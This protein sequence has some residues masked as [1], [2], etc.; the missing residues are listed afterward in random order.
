M[1]KKEKKIW[2]YLKVMVY[3]SKLH[4]LLSY[5]KNCNKYC[6]PKKF[7]LV[8][9]LSK[10]MFDNV[11]IMFDNVRK[12]KGVWQS[13]FISSTLFLFALILFEAYQASS[14]III[15]PM[16]LDLIKLKCKFPI[17]SSIFIF[18]IRTCHIIDIF[19]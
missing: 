19:F 4:I 17:K 13:I 6:V 5:S 9:H 18:S 3:Q 7:I 14:I 11:K 1:L 10:I 2:V 12:K 16:S 15:T 8:H